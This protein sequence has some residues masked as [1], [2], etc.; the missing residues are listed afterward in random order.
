MNNDSIHI[1]E[2][3]LNAIEGLLS[4]SMKGI[5]CLFEHSDIARIMSIPTESTDLFS[6]DNVDKIQELFLK[7]IE[8]PTFA[9]K[10][11]FLSNLAPENYEIILRAYFHIVENSII[12]TTPFKH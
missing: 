2:Q 11:N 9:D 4:Q 10:Q 6:F 3:H 8:Q 5:H 1:E 7:L 12:A